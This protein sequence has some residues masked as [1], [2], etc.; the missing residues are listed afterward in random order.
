MGAC[1]FSLVSN[2]LPF[3][4]LYSKSS[5]SAKTHLVAN[6][7]VLSN[8]LVRLDLAS[9]LPYTMRHSRTQRMR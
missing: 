9:S 8:K 7:A 5:R 4:G 2:R 6:A 3:I 1:R